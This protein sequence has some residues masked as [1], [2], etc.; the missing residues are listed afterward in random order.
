M[1]LGRLPP[2]GY[3]QTPSLDLILHLRPVPSISILFHSLLDIPFLLSHVFGRILFTDLFELEGRRHYKQ[4][5]LAG[6]KIFNPPSSPSFLIFS[7]FCLSLIRVFL[8][9]STSFSV[10]VFDT[11]IDIPIGES[12]D[13][14]LSVLSLVFLLSLLPLLVILSRTSSLLTFSSLFFFFFF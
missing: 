7:V 9:L 3:Q 12:Q 11:D 2:A 10:S 1:H 5:P 13:I 6:R 8:L 4:S 14:C